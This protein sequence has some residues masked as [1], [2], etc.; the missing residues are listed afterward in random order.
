[1]RIFSLS[2]VSTAVGSGKTQ[3]KTRPCCAQ[4]CT[5]QKKK[6][7]VLVPK[8]LQCRRHLLGMSESFLPRWPPFL[9]AGQ[10]S[11][12]GTWVKAAKSL[13]HRGAGVCRE[14]IWK[15]RRTKAKSDSGFAQ[16][17]F[18]YLFSWYFLF[19]SD[20]FARFFSRITKLHGLSQTAGTYSNFPKFSVV[21]EMTNNR[22]TPFFSQSPLCVRCSPNNRHPGWSI[23]QYLDVT[24][25]SASPTEGE[26]FC[27]HHQGKHIC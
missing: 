23:L 7:A 8:S 10:A 15:T 9:S 13:R 14:T 26:S 1:M 4:L 18:E 6:K 22:K 21:A 12:V 11:T 24:G 2:V 5:N 27:Y 16:G 3:E 25:H 19:L 17:S 20:P